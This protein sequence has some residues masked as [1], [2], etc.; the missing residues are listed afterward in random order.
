MKILIYGI[1][2]APELTGIGKYSGEM[3]EFLA[4]AGNDVIVISAPPYYPQWSIGAEYSAWQYKKEY[5]NYVNIWRCPL[6]VPKQPSGLRRII[7]LLSFAITSFPILMAHIFWKP[8][9]IMAI[10]PPFSCAPGAV[11]FSKLAGSRAWLHVQDFEID[12]AFELG[13]MNAEFL[14]NFIR[15]TEHHILKHFDTI[16]TISSKM[17]NKLQEKGVSRSRS[18]LFPN[19]VDTK[20]IYPNG[21]HNRLRD[22]LG[23]TSDEIV[24]LY[25]GNMGQKQGL[26]IIADAA[27]ILLDHNQLRFVLCGDGAGCKKLKAQ[28]QNLSN[29]LWIP[30]QPTER[31]NDLLNLADIHLLPQKKDAADLVMPSKLTG[32]MA[33]GK[34]VIATAQKNTEIWSAIQG[35]GLTVMPGD[36]KAFAKAILDL[37]ED[38][39]LRKR[40]GRNARQYAVENLD[41]NQILTDLSRTLVQ[42]TQS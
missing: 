14:K 38:S 19:W 32:I 26:E 15:R 24:A 16:S 1:N 21:N 5:I 37:S 8:D 20:S 3:A 27:R 7:H 9:I 10:E 25:S 12:A 29:V 31:L 34:P 30:L 40:L 36:V 42:L 39:E 41:K 6:W 4:N 33:S 11:L 23:L 2:Y 35:R 18:V 22:E 28:T 17:Q 13:L